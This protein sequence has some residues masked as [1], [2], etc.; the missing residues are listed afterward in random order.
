MK[1]FMLRTCA[2]VTN[3]VMALTSSQLQLQSCLRVMHRCRNAQVS[4]SALNPLRCRR[5]ARSQ[6][7]LTCGRHSAK[8]KLST[9]A[10][11]VFVYGTLLSEEIV[12]ILLNRN[13]ESHAGRS[14]NF[15]SVAEGTVPK[16][17]CDLQRL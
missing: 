17:C 14:C 12:R 4:P 15:F 16:P 11:T 2:N 10:H 5:H 7:R 3:H 8:R 6:G 1:C 13:P 9:M